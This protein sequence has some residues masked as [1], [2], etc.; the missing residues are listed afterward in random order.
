MSQNS[1]VDPDATQCEQADEILTQRGQR[2]AKHKTQAQ[3]RKETRKEAQA[4]F[5]KKL[6]RKSRNNPVKTPKKPEEMIVVLF[7][8]FMTSLSR[9]DNV[10]LNVLDAVNMKLDYM[11]VPSQTCLK[12]YAKII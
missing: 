11:M 10:M 5:T 9:M 8:I 12:I 2:F 7:S 3:L 1:A 6:R 4:K